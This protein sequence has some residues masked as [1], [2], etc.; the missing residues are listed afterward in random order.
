MES[1]EL[2]ERMLNLIGLS[3][4]SEELQEGFV[5][6]FERIANRR[7]GWI[8]FEMLSDEQ[9]AKVK[10][11]RESGTSDREVLAWIKRCMSVDYDALYNAVLQDVVNEVYQTPTGWKK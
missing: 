8:V 6:A 1:S 3:K 9:V 7:M 11:M 5:Y 4:A 2:R 10:R